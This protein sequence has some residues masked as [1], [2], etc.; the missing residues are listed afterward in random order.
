MSEKARQIILDHS[1]AGCKLRE[2]FFQHN[3]DRVVD[4]ARIMAVS[5]A[6]GGKILFCGNG[7]SAADA[8]HIAA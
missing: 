7:G 6:G 1:S 5:I 2:E 8:Q 4:V 3:A